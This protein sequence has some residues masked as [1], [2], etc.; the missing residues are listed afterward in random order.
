MTAYPAKIDK[1]DRI[2]LYE[3]EQ[4]C[5]QS[6]QNI[7]K[8]TRISKQAVRN[9]ITHLVR[10][11]A[12]LKFMTMMDCSK[13]GYFSYEAWVQLNNIEPEK[14]NQIQ[15]YLINCPSVYWVVSCGGI[16]DYAFG[17]VAQDVNV[18]HEILSSIQ[19]KFPG[20]IQNQSIVVLKTLR[21]YPR[22][23]LHS[24]TRDERTRPKFILGGSTKKPKLS[25]VD[26]RLLVAISS[27]ARI[28]LIKL[29]K[30]VGVTPNTVRIKLRQL[31]NVGV[32]QSYRA[33][34]QPAVIGIQNYEILLATQNMTEK[35][36]LELE[37]Y[38]RL[39]P[40]MI[41]LLSGFGR[42]DIIIAFDAE[43][44]DQF[45]QILTEIRVRFGSI[46][47]E[48]QYVPIL[49]VHKYDYFIQKNAVSRV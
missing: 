47:R 28:S 26:I 24:Q 30:V 29:A 31:E 17:I 42:W 33:I 46:I 44:A 19:K 14:R 10:N 6:L 20:F 32:I 25:E 35:K 8:K 37:T 13:F 22:T 43:N 12:I 48:Y 23:F 38:C 21:S 16:Y 41:L 5:R 39:H 2:I 34:L 15:E 4:N 40:H 18:A 7:A 9:R 27:N 45:Q 49:Q 3:L 11:G 1:K 36:E